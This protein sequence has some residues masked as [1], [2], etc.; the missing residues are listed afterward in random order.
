MMELTERDILD[1][2]PALAEMKVQVVSWLSEDELLAQLPA[3]AGLER[4]RA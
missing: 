4:A 3:M 2:L 1:Q